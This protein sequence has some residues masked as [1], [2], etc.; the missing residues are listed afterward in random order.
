M[1]N[2]IKNKLEIIG[3]NKEINKVLKFIKGDNDIIDFNTITPIPPWV[4]KGHPVPGFK[5]ITSFS[6]KDDIKYGKE[7]IELEWCALNW[8]TKWNAYNCYQ[9]IDNKNI[10]YFNTAWSG[11]PDLMRKLAIIF[12]TITFNYSY[13][14]EDFGNN[15]GVYTFKDTDIIKKYEPESY[16]KEAYELAADIRRENLEED[17]NLFYNSLIDN[18][19]HIEEE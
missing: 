3:T 2:H 18:Y 11:I 9:D 4:F 19:E 13:A 15:I 5:D 10:I 8:K 12:P 7:N 1:P 16:S 17:R 14:D 6:I